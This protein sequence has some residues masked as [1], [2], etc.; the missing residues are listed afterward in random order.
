MTTVG[1][2]AGSCLRPNISQRSA[3]RISRDRPRTGRTTGETEAAAQ[4]SAMA[5]TIIWLRVL[6]LILKLAGPLSNGPAR[7]FDPQQPADDRRRAGPGLGVDPEHDFRRLERR[8]VEAAGDQ[9]DV[10]AGEI[11]EPALELGAAERDLVTL[12]GE[13]E[14][15]HD[16]RPASLGLHERRGAIKRQLGLRQ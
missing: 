8:G 16:Q 7:L 2:T 14:P 5:A 4:T 3:V 6:R 12:A 1:E 10:F 9:G 13:V 15:T 11:D